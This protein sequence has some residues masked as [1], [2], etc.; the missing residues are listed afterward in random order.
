MGITDGTE[1]KPKY[2]KQEDKNN[3]ENQ[4]VGNFKY[5]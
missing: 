5:L 1:D 3:T 2:L 4:M